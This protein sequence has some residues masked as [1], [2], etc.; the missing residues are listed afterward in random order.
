[1]LTAAAVL[2]SSS[3]LFAHE[4][5]DIILRIGAASVQPDES[6]SLISTT[7]TGALAG[8][9][10]GVGNSTQLGINVVYMLTDSWGLEVLAA[11]PFEHDITV[12]GLEQ[13]GFSVSDLGETK[14]LPPTVSALYFFGDSQSMIRPYLG[15]GLNYTTFFEDS[16]SAQA[17]SVLGASDL[18]LDDSFG[19]SLR[20]GID[21]HLGDQWILN[22]SV[23]NIDID[24]DA[25]FNSALGRVTADVEI[26]PWVYMIS[27]GYQF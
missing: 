2:L 1:A 16:L 22:T 27:L 9:A 6:S 26:D 14:H 3:T 8:T 15:A 21:W 19:L 4:E 10:A 24:T 20:A 5:G 12:S 25:G 18:E 7:A 11:T 23:W 13:Y 17:S